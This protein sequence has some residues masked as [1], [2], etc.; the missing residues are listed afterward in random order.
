MS[1]SESTNLQ[2]LKQSVQWDDGVFAS[3]RL[4]TQNFTAGPI[5]QIPEQDLHPFGRGFAP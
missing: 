1:C 4:N 5:H 3:L 2:R